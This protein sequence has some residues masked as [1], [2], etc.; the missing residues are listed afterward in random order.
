MIVGVD[1]SSN[2]AAAVSA[3]AMRA[4][5]ANTDV[6]VLVALDVR[7]ALATPAIGDQTTDQAGSEEWVHAMADGAADEL[8]R[9]GLS[10]EV[11]LRHGDPK[12]VLLEDASAVDTDCIFLGARGHSKVQRLLLGS[13]SAAVSARAP[14]SVEV[15]RS[16]I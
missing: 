9:G 5:P 4:W 8:R 6:L 16:G 3:V 7:L 13:V 2:S 1:G 10:V 11:A 12:N 14:C 15:V